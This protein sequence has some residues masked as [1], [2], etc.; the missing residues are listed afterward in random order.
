MNRSLTILSGRR[1]GQDW[2]EEESVRLFR[3]RFLVYSGR[4]YKSFESHCIKRWRNGLCGVQVDRRGSKKY[5]KYMYDRQI[6][7]TSA[8]CLKETM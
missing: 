4:A 5:K 8:D 1:K 6:N 7:G 3:S 2:T